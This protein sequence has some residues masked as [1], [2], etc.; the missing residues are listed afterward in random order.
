MEGEVF[1]VVAND[2]QGGALLFKLSLRAIFYISESIMATT[3]T[4]W[5]SYKLLQGEIC[6][7]ALSIFSL[8]INF[9]S[10]RPRGTDDY[11]EA[12]LK[13]HIPREAESLDVS[14]QVR[15]LGRLSVCL[16]KFTK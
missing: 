13:D 12:K 5:R 16:H 15:L 9:V 14:I 8:H 1:I 3:S 11:T 7:M 2:V 6:H 10:C 4:S